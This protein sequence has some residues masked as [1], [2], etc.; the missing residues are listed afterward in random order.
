MS[1]SASQAAAFYRE[2]AENHLVW[3]IRDAAGIPAPA[4]ECGVRAMPF[5]SSLARVR[6]VIAEVPAY[7]GFV[8]VQLCWA[9]YRDR[10]LPGLA[11]DGL[12]VGVN[13][14]GRMAT[15]YDV[16]PAAV[17]ASVEAALARHENR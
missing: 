6:T 11:R 10:W 4:G 2:V 7:A 1:P 14:S 12:R 13:W 5:W 16:E 9:E 15:G 8:P 3:T 17:R